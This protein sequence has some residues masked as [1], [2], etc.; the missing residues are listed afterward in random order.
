[1]KINGCAPLF[2]GRES[3]EEERG[4]FLRLTENR[5]GLQELPKSLRNL[6]ECQI[7]LKS[8]KKLILY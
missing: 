5:K 4:S 7:F 8:V 1:M 2:W 3:K 6:K